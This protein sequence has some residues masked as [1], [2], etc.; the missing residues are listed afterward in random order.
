[1]AELSYSEALNLALREEMR[2]DPTVF[3]MGE[4]VAV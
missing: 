2:R 3:V 1:M 4:D